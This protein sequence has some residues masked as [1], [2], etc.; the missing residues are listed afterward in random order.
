MGMHAYV[1]AYDI[2]HL[3]LNVLNTMRV[4]FIMISIIADLD[5][6]HLHGNKNVKFLHGRKKRCCELFSRIFLLILKERGHVYKCAVPLHLIYTTITHT[7]EAELER[8]W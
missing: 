2:K 6:L 4:C 1:R 7:R 8:L 5:V 3:G